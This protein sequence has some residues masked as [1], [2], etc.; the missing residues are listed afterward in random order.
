MHHRFEPDAPG[1]WRRIFCV[2]D[3][4]LNAH[5]TS[6]KLFGLEMSFPKRQFLTATYAPDMNG[7]LWGAPGF[8][9]AVPMWAGPKDRESEPQALQE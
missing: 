7:L 6:S 8:P 1:R 3:V 2:R 4:G 9:K 5:C